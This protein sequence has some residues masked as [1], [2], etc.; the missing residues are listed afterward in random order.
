V[1]TFDPTPRPALRKAADANVHPSMPA[2]AEQSHEDL[3]TRAGS[4]ASDTMRP[5]AKDKLVELSVEIPKSLRKELRKRAEEQGMT[6]DALVTLYL[7]NRS[8]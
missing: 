3:S 5:P 8:N 2:V 4:S 7:R 6:L 1:S